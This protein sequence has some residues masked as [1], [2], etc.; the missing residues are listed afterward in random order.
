MLGVPSCDA[1]D[2]ARVCSGPTC[3]PTQHNHE[4][5]GDCRRKQPPLGLEL[6][7]QVAGAR[8][9]IPGDTKRCHSTALPVN[10]ARTG[11]IHPFTCLQHRKLTAR[12]FRPHATLTAQQLSDCALHSCVSPPAWRLVCLQGLPLP[13]IPVIIGEF[14]AK[15]YF[16][17][18]SSANKDTTAYKAEDQVWL[19]ETAAYLRSLY[20][21][22]G[23]PLSWLFW[24]WN[25]NSGA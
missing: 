18:S 23:V 17:D 19:T 20:A 10:M 3:L 2:R 13:R 12:L 16:G 5:Q 7:S 21:K 14:G 8:Q 24:A 22:A 6:G 4:R 15:D 9:L 25:A 1:A 11:L